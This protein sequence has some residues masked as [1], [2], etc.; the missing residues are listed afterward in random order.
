MGSF[1]DCELISY[2]EQDIKSIVPFSA[3]QDALILM[4][5]FL[6]NCELHKVP[7]LYIG[8]RIDEKVAGYL[9]FY[10]VKRHNA[11][12]STGEVAKIL[13]IFREFQTKER[14]SDDNVTDDFLLLWQASMKLA[15]L[16]VERRNTCIAIVHDFF[17]WME[18]HGYLRYRVQDRERSEYRRLPDHYIFPI[19]SEKK[20]VGKKREEKWV[21]TLKER[22]TTSS[23]GRRATPTSEQIERLKLRVEAHLRNSRRNSL[24]IG[25]A[26]ET[27]ARVSEI[28][29]VKRQDLP[30]EDEIGDLYANGTKFISV[31]IHRKNRGESLLYVPL[32]LVTR[33]LSYILHDTER[34]VAAQRSVAEKKDP[35]YVFLSEK[36]G[37][38]TTDSVT[39][40]CGR[41]F[42]AVGIKN[43][44]IHR[45]RARFI[46][47]VIEQS[48]DDLVANGQSVDLNSDWTESIL[49]QA[50]RRMGHSH[51]MSLRPYLNE[52]KI[53]RIQVDGTMS[54]RTTKDRDIEVVAFNSALSG[55]L[56][57]LDKIAL[58]GERQEVVAELRRMADEI[59][60]EASRSGR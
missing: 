30:T 1:E 22:G 2:L 53:R 19:A 37:V 39:R 32:R 49:T 8:G 50:Q 13:R 25:W 26:L 7:T 10:H 42:R 36:G 3:P 20:I 31:T 16:K 6:Y 4:V 55:R 21:S 38:L 12:S 34:K 57:E 35:S 44:N 41:F 9:R 24:L 14:V 40:I 28:L 33:T 58:S 18:R 48:L 27:G 52:I 60:A 47:E 43:A 54:G 23:F 15:K 46:T 11:Q 56:S 29:Q 59:E 51:I 45:L 17:V 5:D